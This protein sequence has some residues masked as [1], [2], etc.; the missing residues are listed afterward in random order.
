MPEEKP[1]YQL[2]IGVSPI[3]GFGER[4]AIL[5]FWLPA[6]GMNICFGPFLFAAKALVCGI[7]P[8]V[9]LLCKHPMIFACGYTIGFT[10]CG[11]WIYLSLFQFFS[12]SSISRT[13]WE[14]RDRFFCLAPICL[15]NAAGCLNSSSFRLS[16]LWEEETRSF[17]W[18]GTV[19]LFTLSSNLK[20]IQNAGVIIY[21]G[22]WVCWFL[23]TN[24]TIVVV[25]FF[26]G[27]DLRLSM[28]FVFFS[29]PRPAGDEWDL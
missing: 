24:Q 27:N 17:C 16:P 18:V 7:V 21:D 9:K 5:Y 11:F 19:L 23:F 28:W 1:L 26:T 8:S 12:I 6:R 10:C 20:S 2:Y 14:D 29:R 3:F 4:Y 15:F 25:H 13:D 22:P